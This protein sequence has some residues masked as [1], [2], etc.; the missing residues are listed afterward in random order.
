MGNDLVRE[1][2]EISCQNTSK[3]WKRLFNQSKCLIK[4]SLSEERLKSTKIFKFFKKYILFSI[5]LLVF[6]QYF[7]YSE[8]AP[9]ESH[10]SPHKEKIWGKERIRDIYL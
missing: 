6:F 8:K 3:R 9:A 2:T 4:I 5:V 7:V 1:L 10:F